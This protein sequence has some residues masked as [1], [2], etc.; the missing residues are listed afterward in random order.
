M[1]GRVDGS[2]A[3]RVDGRAVFAADDGGLTVFAEPEPY[4]VAAHR[5]PAWKVVLPLGGHVTVNG[6]AGASGLAGGTGASRASRAIGTGAV[7]P[8]GLA[9]TCGSSSGFV[10]VFLDPWLLRA[11]GAPQLLEPGRARRLLDALGDLDAPDPAAFRAELGRA[12]TGPPPRAVDPRVPYAVAAAARSGLLS[13][14][15]A[16]VGLS[17]VRLRALVRTEAG[18]PLSALR[19]WRRLG[20]AVG[21]LLDPVAGGGVAGAAT[22]AG[23]AD[24]AHLTRTAGRL[25]GRTPASLHRARQARRAR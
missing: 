3:G 8:P 13:E 14:V 15:A 1:N 21:A 4:E 6:T 22:A 16:E 12:L 18:V 23:F 19:Q 10:A 9:H 24:Q 11:G 7:V 2:L 20:A 17:P 5:H 25:I